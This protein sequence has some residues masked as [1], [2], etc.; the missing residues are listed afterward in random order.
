MKILAIETS[1]STFSLALA[2]QDKLIA[3]VFWHSGLTHSERLIPAINWL[4][5]QAG[6]KKEE[7]EKIAVT[8]GPGS[9]T[10]IRVGL[11]C[12]RT[13]A[14]GLNIP[15]VGI[16]TLTLIAMAIPGCGI[17]V[18]AAIDALRGEVYCRRPKK[19]GIEI[20]SVG[21]FCSDLKKADDIVLVA[22]NAALSYRKELK[23]ALKGKVC[24]AP[25]HLNFPRAS[26]LAL[27]ASTMAG[28]GYLNVHPL[29]I[30]KSWAEERPKPT[31]GR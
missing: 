4:L 22:G 20:R 10:G 29:Y 16:D 5:P 12:A 15:L 7:L 6:W 2:D 18:H 17:P 13:I 31:A 11:T 19:K 26:V 3:E 25:D 28:T 24:F 1:G 9:F 23:G 30:R 21:D 27:K 14:Q 8:V